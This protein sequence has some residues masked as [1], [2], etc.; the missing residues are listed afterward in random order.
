[1]IGGTYRFEEEADDFNGGRSTS[2]TLVIPATQSGDSFTFAST[3]RQTESTTGAV[4][5]DDSDTGVGTYD[6]PTVTFKLEGTTGV[7]TV[8]EGGAVIEFSE[9]S[10]VYVRVEEP[11]QL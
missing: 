9:T 3:F 1:M 6:Y 10:F 4:I 8:R 2:A 7:G 5:T 11:S